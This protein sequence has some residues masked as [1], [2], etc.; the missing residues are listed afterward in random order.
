MGD[1]KDWILYLNFL[2]FLK[3]VL[4]EEYNLA[5]IAGCDIGVLEL[6]YIGYTVIMYFVGLQYLE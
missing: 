1:V 5:I 6:E 3:S 2:N 4:I